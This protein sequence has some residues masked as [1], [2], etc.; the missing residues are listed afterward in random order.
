MRPEFDDPLRV[1]GLRHGIHPTVLPQEAFPLRKVI[2]LAVVLCE[3]AILGV[4][5]PVALLEVLVQRLE[6]P[7]AFAIPREK[8]TLQPPPNP[9]A[10]RRPPNP[11]FDRNASGSIKRHGVLLLYL[12]IFVRL[13]LTHP[14]ATRIAIDLTALLENVSGV[15][16][17]MLA[18]VSS[19]LPLGLDHEY[20]LYINA[21][22][23]ARMEDL[24]S[25][26]GRGLSPFRLIEASRRSRPLRLFWQQSV[27]PIAVKARNIDVVHSPSF[28]MPIATAGA[29]HVLTVHDMTSFLLPG[30]HPWYRRGRVYEWA[31]RSSILRADLVSVP[32]A[33]TRHDVLR[34]VPEKDPHDVRVIPCGVGPAFT[35]RSPAEYAPVLAHLGI[36]WPYILY[37]GT[38]DPRKNL[39]R[40]IDAYATVVARGNL[41]E[42]LVIAGQHGW[43][44][45]LAFQDVPAA[46]RER[47]HE[48]GY[49]TDSDLPRL[50]AGATLFAYPSL[51]EGFGFPP[52]EAMACGTPV[53]ASNS[54]ALRENL[55]GAA[56]LVS[57]QDTQSL[58]DA[59]ERMAAD[60][61][62]R[63]QYR[64]AGL[65]HAKR[66]QWANF[67]RSTAACYEEVALRRRRPAVTIRAAR[68]K[69]G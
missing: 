7:P 4:R 9:P 33:A 66:Y 21:E 52:L 50:Y 55:E 25:G 44:G 32:S 60:A 27:L 30:Y 10:H 65:Q 41:R 29:G 45:G 67:A 64:D 47:I 46:V 3:D 17:Y 2:G 5:L 56:Y 18:M 23:R 24:I 40:L 38:L 61:P 59:L 51:M 34:A 62:L 1:D 14:M 42:H 58:A 13:W 22:D 12:H 20:F 68:S 53:I 28:V 15:D 39:A 19:L 35:P 31:I 48:I 11:A 8:K 43:R 37:V 26:L 63:A 57:P 6:K 49:V 16:R 36:P 69:A 54:S